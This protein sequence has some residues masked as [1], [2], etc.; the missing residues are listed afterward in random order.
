M[1]RTIT[2]LG[3]IHLISASC[4][5]GV[6]LTDADTCNTHEGRGWKMFPPCWSEKLKG[7]DYFRGLVS[8]GRP[9]V[10]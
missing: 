10:K 7:R 4:E 1:S 8:D 2:L 9:L 6:Y 3:I 5:V